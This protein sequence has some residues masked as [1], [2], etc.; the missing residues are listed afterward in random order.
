MLV[1][2]VESVA[3]AAVQLLRRSLCRQHTHHHSLSC[4]LMHQT[5]LAVT[6]CRRQSSRIKPASLP[7]E[8]CDQQPRA[9]FHLLRDRPSLN[10]PSRS[11]PA[12]CSTTTDRNIELPLIARNDRAARFAVPKSTQPLFRFSLPP[13]P[14]VRLTSSMSMLDSAPPVCW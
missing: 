9:T 2:V 5:R 1:S 14:P 7:L 11:P 6:T 8:P 10:L 3:E 12:S 4:A 13:H